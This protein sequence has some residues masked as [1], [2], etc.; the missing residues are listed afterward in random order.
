MAHL[1]LNHAASAV[2]GIA[3]PH[4]STVTAIL[5][6]AQL[7]LFSQ[8][9]AEQMIGRVRALTTGPFSSDRTAS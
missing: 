9:D 5:R 3:E 7:G 6:G 8:D 1:D 2:A 4:Q